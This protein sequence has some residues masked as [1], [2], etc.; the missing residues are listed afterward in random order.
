MMNKL[1]N[2]VYL[3]RA[4]NYV[5]SSSTFGFKTM[6]MVRHESTKNKFLSFAAT[7]SITEIWQGKSHLISLLNFYTWPL[8]KS[9]YFIGSSSTCPKSGCQFIIFT[10]AHRIWCYSTFVISEESHWT[11]WHT[12]YCID[13][14]ECENICWIASL[15]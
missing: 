8:K 5:N 14:F 6:K 9:R 13:G 1:Q 11:Q 15:E 12:K 2:A 10:V 7:R 4:L 3:I